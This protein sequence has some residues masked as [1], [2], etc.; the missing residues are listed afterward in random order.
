LQPE[1]PRSDLRLE[2][3][4]LSAAD[5]FAKL[6]REQ[7]ALGAEIHDDLG[8]QLAGIWCLIQAHETS[9]AAEDHP[10]QEDVTRMTEL[11]K[12][13]L[14]MT[15]S[16]ACRLSP[17]AACVG[18][19]PAALDALIRKTAAAHKI[20]FQYNCARPLPMDDERATQLYRIAQ[21]AVANAVQ[22]A[23]PKEIIIDLVSQSEHIILSVI[24]RGKGISKAD[25][26]EGGVGVRLMRYR[27]LMLGGVLTIGNVRGRAGTKVTCKIPVLNHKSRSA[28]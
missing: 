6:E 28:A 22:H 11:L 3:T 4:V 21:E 7:R 5:I 9:L 17:G 10:Q 14:A 1:L 16:L 27:A 2:Y 24:D 13:A 18:G 8:Q 20:A 25:A 26:E 12:N 15:H 23:D 19:V